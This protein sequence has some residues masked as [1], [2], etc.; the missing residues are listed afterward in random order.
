MKK[1]QRIINVQKHERC[2]TPFITKTFQLKVKLFPFFKCVNTCLSDNFKIR[3][4]A[5]LLLRE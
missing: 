3:K 5:G 2:F 4:A 1:I